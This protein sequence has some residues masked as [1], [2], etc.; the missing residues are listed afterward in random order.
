M[1]LAHT[2]F[3]VDRCLCEETHKAKNNL[4]VAAAARSLCILQG[5]G[6]G[7]TNVH[8]SDNHYKLSQGL[9]V[10][11]IKCRFVEGELP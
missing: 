8:F 7:S 5:D 9:G 2:E 4:S 3:K 11:V 10:I 6:L 1:K